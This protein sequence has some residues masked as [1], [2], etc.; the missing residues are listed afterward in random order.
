MKKNQRFVEFYDV[1]DASRA[2][3]EMK[4]KEIIGRSVVIDYS[5]PG[6]DYMIKKFNHQFNFK[7]N[8]YQ[9]NENNKIVKSLAT[10]GR[11]SSPN[12]QR[13]NETA[14]N[15]V[16][17][18]KQRQDILRKSKSWKG[19]EKDNDPRFLIKE[20]AII[21]KSGLCKDT[22]TTLMIKNIPNKYRYVILLLP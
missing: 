2:L 18:P 16:G 8:N 5:R 17:S 7:N 20:D 12:T 4:G 14:T 19:K 1:R 9:Y 11:S 3:S 15:S 6:G 13:D 22:R 10:R 21:E